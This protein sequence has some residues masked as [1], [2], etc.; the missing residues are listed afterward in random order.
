MPINNTHKVL[1]LK[2][3]G[4]G[5]WRIACPVS[6]GCDVRCF[7]HTR[8]I[9]C[10]DPDAVARSVLRCY[11]FLVIDKT[12]RRLHLWPFIGEGIIDFPCTFARACFLPPRVSFHALTHKYNLRLH[13]CIYVLRSVSHF[14]PRHTSLLPT[15]HLC[16][17]RPKHHIPLSS[18]RLSARPTTRFTAFCFCLSSC[19]YRVPHPELSL[20]GIDKSLPETRII[21]DVSISGAMYS[22]PAVDLSNRHT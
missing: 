11:L 9:C 16:V 6:V 2:I 1:R 21:R 13:R 22:F 12:P 18:P 14:S 8:G 7:L 4:Y 15:A 3:V 20:C 19:F 10:C 17:F 5:N